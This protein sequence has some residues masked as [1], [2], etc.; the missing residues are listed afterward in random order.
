I[1]GLATVLATWALARAWFGRAVGLLAAGL[2]ATLLWHVILSRT[3]VRAVCAPLALALVLWLLWRTLAHGRLLDALLLGLAL[4][5]GLQTYL[6]TR[7]IPP[8]LVVLFLVEWARSRALLRTRGPL[9]LAAF[10]V[11][12][13]VFAPLGRYFLD[14]PDDFW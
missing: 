6:S 2:L 14:H 3:G 7:L 10:F 13:V 9:L 8:L 1:A 5:L 12:A 11:A 4:G